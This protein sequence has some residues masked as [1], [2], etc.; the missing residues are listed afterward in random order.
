MEDVF[1]R[2]MKLTGVT[3]AEEVF[4]RFRAQRETAKRLNYL[5]V[6][7]EEEK[8]QLETTQ[9]TLLAELEAFKFA[10][11]KDK[12]ET[13]DQITALKEEIAAEEDAHARLQR[14][15]EDLDALLL[16]IKRLLYE[17][18][19]LLDVIP[20]PAVPEWTAEA[21]D[22]QQLVQVLRTR[23]SLAGVRADDVRSRRDVS[24]MAMPS[25]PTSGAPSVAGL[26][27]QSHS[28][29]KEVET[30]VPT[31]KELLMKEPVRPPPSDEEEDIPSRSYLKRQAQLI[32]DT[33]CRRKGFRTP[34]PRR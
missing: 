29:T 34:Y 30:A 23:Y 27:I 11:V 25:N 5:Q 26:S 20:E 33:K 9:T 4:D 1:Q 21:R 17:L 31:Y 18:C 24:T 8:L 16:E 19:K 3:D 6:T 2:L 7:I 28:T 14:E 12:D 22:V 32:V 15:S 10:S 13:Q